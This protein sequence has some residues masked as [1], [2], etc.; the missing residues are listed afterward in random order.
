MKVAILGT[1]NVGQTLGKGFAGLG[2]SVIIGTRDPQS[3]VARRAVAA[4]G[5][6][7]AMTFTDAAHATDLAVLATSWSGAEPVTKAAAA[8]LAGKLVIDAVNALDADFA[9][10]K[11]AL[12]LDGTTSVGEKV[13]AWMPNAKVVKAFN[14][15]GYPVM[16]N[17]SYAPGRPTMFIA[18]N[19]GGAKQQTTLLLREFGWDTV[20]M[21]G[22]EAAR[23][24][25]P[26]APLW[27]VHALRTGQWT[28][29]F[30]L[31]SSN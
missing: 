27:I 8:G 16:V 23:L 26:L 5:R 18:G 15:V 13:Q 22:I 17:P 14:S 24:I 6:A 28:H 30:K 29:A 10:G 12:A 21:G 25:E 7:T 20:D 1:G 19:D 9:K 4:I 11:V 31:L 3:E 2:H